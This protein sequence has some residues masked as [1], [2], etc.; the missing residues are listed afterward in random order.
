MISL[1]AMTEVQP[2]YV[3]PGAQ[4]TSNH[5]LA[6]ARRA[7]RGDDLGA[8][9]WVGV[10]DPLSAHGVVTSYFNNVIQRGVVRCVVMQPVPAQCI[11]IAVEYRRIMAA[12]AM[13]QYRSSVSV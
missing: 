10:I 9:Q 4:Q 8:P 12:S 11:G 7:Y 1:G 13:S 6:L 2:K 3:D 5:V